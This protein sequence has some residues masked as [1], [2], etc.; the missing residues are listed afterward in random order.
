M[1]AITEILE[2]CRKLVSEGYQIDTQGL[3]H[4]IEDKLL[5]KEKQQIIDFGHTIK[6]E[7]AF[8]SYSDRWLEEMYE[9]HIKNTKE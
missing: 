1:T 7:L 8:G 5:E 9:Y 2:H 6:D 3:I 4:W